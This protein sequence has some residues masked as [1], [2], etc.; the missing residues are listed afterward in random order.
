MV[1]CTIAGNGAAYNA[2]G[3]DGVY[4]AE[5]TARLTNCLIGGN[6]GRWEAFNNW[7]E[8]NGGSFVNCAAQTSIVGGTDCV[9]IPGENEWTDQFSDVVNFIPH[10]KSV[11]IDAGLNYLP[12]QSDYGLDLLG[13]P[14]KCVRLDI[15][16][17]EALIRGL[18]I[19]FY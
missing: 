2:T 11:M 14:R 8:V 18:V 4:V 15:G 9:L 12:A 6:N 3:H 17:Y 7:S 1:N 13:N 5:A 16:A 10:K 19:M